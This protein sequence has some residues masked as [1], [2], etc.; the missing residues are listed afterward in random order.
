[1]L[2]FFL[3]YLCICQNVSV[4]SNADVDAASRETVALSKAMGGVTIVRKGF[5]DIIARNNEGD[6]V[7]S[8]SA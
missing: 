3:V 8:T 7:F 6:S 1:M 2:Y 4:S 5:V